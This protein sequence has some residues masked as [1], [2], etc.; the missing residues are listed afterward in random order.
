MVDTVQGF[1]ANIV[2]DGNDI[3][4][5]TVTT[6]LSRSREVLSKNVMDNVGAAINI[7][8]LESGALNISGFVNQVEH[9]KLEVTW[10]KKAP[11]V[12]TLTV[13]EG[14]TTDASWTGL[15]VLSTFD[16]EPVGDGMWEFTLS[17]DTSTAT[18]YTP[19]IA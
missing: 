2:L 5:V 12:F 9:N 8:G 1:L 6:P 7:D 17:G 3:T 16:V 14:L 4:S 11:V 19:S 18:I 15:V 13:A 10:A